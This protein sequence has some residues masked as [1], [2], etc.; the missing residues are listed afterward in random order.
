MR[1][2]P[3][4]ESRLLTLASEIGGLDPSAWIITEGGVSREEVK[5][6]FLTRGVGFTAKSI[7]DVSGFCRH[8]LGPL[9]QD[10]QILSPSTRQEVLR[11]LLGEPERL[12]R[13]PSFR[14]LKRQRGFFRKL[15]RAIQSARMTYS[16]VPER[17][18][19]ME[20][21]R[22]A[23]IQN[24][25]REE[26]SLLILDYEEWLQKNHAW[27]QP[28]FIL[29]AV[30]V[31]GTPEVEIEL[32]SRIV[33]IG[34]A[35]GES[36]AEALWDALRARVGTERL[37][38][39]DLLKE[40]AAL[41][42]QWSWE[43]WH[44]LDDA[45][46]AMCDRLAVEARE[47]RL[48][49]NGVLMPDIPVVRRSFKRALTERGIE[50]KDPRDPTRL[51]WEEA[52]KNALLPLDTVSR[53]FSQ[54]TVVSLLNSSWVR[55][56]K[57]LSEDLR[58]KRFLHQQILDLGI[59]EGLESYHVEKLD[60]F[61]PVLKGLSDEFSGKMRVAQVAEKHFE[62]LQLNPEVETW[63]SEFFKETWERFVQDLTVIGEVGKKAPVLYWLDRLRSRLEDATPPFERVQW[64]CG[65]ELF[66]LGQTP[67]SYPERLWCLALPASYS[68]LNLGGDYYLSD[69]EREILAGSF[70][71][72]SSRQESETRIQ[73]LKNWLSH[74]REAVF[75]DATYDWNGSERET[76]DALLK[77]LGF[78]I[79]GKKLEKGS[80]PRWS[81]SFLAPTTFQERSIRLDPLD[82]KEIRASD[83]EAFSRCEFLGLVQGRWR[84]QESKPSDREIRPDTRGNILHAAVKILVENR[85]ENGD[86]SVS[87]E[88]ALDR[89]WNEKKPK[90]LFRSARL[91]R[92]AKDN[93]LPILESFREAEIKYFERAKIKTIALESPKLRYSTGKVDVIGTPDRI[94][95]HPDGLV[96]ID[97]KTGEGAVASDMIEHG[98]RLQLPIYALAAQNEFKKPILAL[99][100][101]SLKK[102]HSRSRGLYQKSVVGKD[103]GKLLTS[104][105]KDSVIQTS[106]EEAL[107]ALSEQIENHID[108]F[109]SGRV[110]V[111]PKAY[112]P[113]KPYAECEGCLGRDICGQRRF[114]D[115]GE[116]GDDG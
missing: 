59:R 13:M 10:S 81:R 7:Q 42:A 95:E 102:V 75:L 18:A 55:W 4:L 111:K 15:D 33:V 24:P 86:F 90:G 83:I 113:A 94:D 2:S 116:G 100:F 44:T 47:G 104:Q 109:M 68:A 40:D 50:L 28:R 71:V 11:K 80:L 76:I 26:L 91:E 67:L 31:L 82:R 112:D 22:A 78:E 99:Q 6:A 37:L 32:P 74:A 29:A 16:N 39:N 25:L 101:F 97:Y 36:R 103:P 72:R 57:D 30:A 54:E 87:C 108:G 88:D 19:Q 14:R 66:R 27:D 79:E 64:K 110:E 106:V 62:I 41:P 98:Y 77:E 63:V 5:D 46:E 48:G 3:K 35:P 51:K 89:A 65:L 93:M 53:R 96:V 43:E 114:F 34:S 85:L 52:V 21:L 23:E 49:E 20:R 73:V 8:I 56:T 60:G 84:L 45:V 92:F 58:K 107:G 70:A 61:Y 38:L 115:T 9:V 17:E 1:I 69:R 12:E 105:S